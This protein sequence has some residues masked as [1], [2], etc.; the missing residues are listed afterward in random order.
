M[1]KSHYLARRFSTRAHLGLVR[2]TLNERPPAKCPATLGKDAKPDEMIVGRENGSARHTRGIRA[3][4][5]LAIKEQRYSSPGHAVA[6]HAG[7]N[8]RGRPTGRL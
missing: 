6:R 3:L 8:L 1:A 5:H 7:L 2:Q 4:R